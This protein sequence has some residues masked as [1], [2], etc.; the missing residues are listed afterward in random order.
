MA[1]LLS[2][3]D[4]RVSYDTTEVVHGVT[5]DIEASKVSAILGVN[6]AGKTA[7]ALAVAGLASATGTISF[8][9]KAINSVTPWARSHMGLALVQEGRRLFHHL[10]VEENLRLA[11]WR[12]GRSAAEIGRQLGFVEDL[13][14]VLR[15]KLREPSSRLSGGEQQMLAVG[16]GLMTFPKLLILDEPTAGL[17]PK[18]VTE[19]LN[20]IR[21]LADEGYSTVV[22]DQSV[23]TARRL[24]ET[25]YL[26]RVGKLVR[27]MPVSEIDQSVISDYL[28]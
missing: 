13:F 10:T 22:I 7:L 8:M 1:F 23:S 26:M 21:R 11:A 5:M 2:L 28:T 4:V 12:R 24:A 25:A 16:Q 14:P 15:R 19:M 6:G 18:V 17:A 27:T 20:S 9:G 3:Q